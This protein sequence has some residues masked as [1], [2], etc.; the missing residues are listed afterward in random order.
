MSSLLFMWHATRDMSAVTDI[1]YM[2][3]LEGSSLIS[4]NN[5]NYDDDI[6]GGTADDTINDEDLRWFFNP[7]ISAWDTSSVTAMA[8]TFHSCYNFDQG[9]PFLGYFACI[10]LWRCRKS[11]TFLPTFLPACLWQ[12]FRFGMSLASPTCG[13]CL[14]SLENSIAA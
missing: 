5:Y 3:F 1:S 14:C 9:M 4:R 13:A 12:M 2:T 6:W 11:Y 7:D 10:K 8:A